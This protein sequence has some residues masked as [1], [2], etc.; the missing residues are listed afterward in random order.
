MPPIT[1]LDHMT[2]IFARYGLFEHEV[3]MQVKKPLF[4]VAKHRLAFLFIVF[5]PDSR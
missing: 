1:Q 5:N 3:T 4:F 2:H